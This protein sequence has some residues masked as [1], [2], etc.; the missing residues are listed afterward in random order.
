MLSDPRFMSSRAR[1]VKLVPFVFSTLYVHNKVD[2]SLG[3]PVRH[4]TVEKVV[5]ISNHGGWIGGFGGTV[6][7]E[8]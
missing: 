1:E 4:R 7:F 6:E 2:V 3:P 8:V 5:I